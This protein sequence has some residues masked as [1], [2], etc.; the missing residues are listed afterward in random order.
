MQPI[1]L[2]DF[3]P[4]LL[5]ACGLPI[6]DAMQGRKPHDLAL[7][8]ACALEPSLDPSCLGP[9]CFLSKIPICGQGR[10]CR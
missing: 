7:S 5:E 9:L 1:T 4:T 10:S 8:E 6:P 2:L 3:A